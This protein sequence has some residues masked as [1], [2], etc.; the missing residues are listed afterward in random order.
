MSVT[1]RCN[2]L[3][4]WIRNVN[5]TN[6]YYR[7]IFNPHFPPI[8]IQ[9][10]QHAFYTEVNNVQQSK[11]PVISSLLFSILFCLEEKKKN[12]WIAKNST[13]LA[14]FEGP[15]SCSLAIK[16]SREMK[17]LQRM[18]TIIQDSP[19]SELE[20]YVIPI[21]ASWKFVILYHHLGCIQFQY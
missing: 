12:D 21:A 15:S 17:S 13:L 2:I 9:T 6:I 1:K 3:L 16:W 10:M 14:T 8:D 19:L 11:H 20:A 18:Y 7:Q 5:V 4:H